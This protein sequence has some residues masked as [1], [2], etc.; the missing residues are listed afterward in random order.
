VTTDSPDPDGS[1]VKSR[2]TA[3]KGAKVCPRKSFD[4]S[5][6]A[7]R[8]IPFKEFAIEYAFYF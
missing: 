1:P 6:N 2:E 5:A 8:L 4:N 3:V 7:E